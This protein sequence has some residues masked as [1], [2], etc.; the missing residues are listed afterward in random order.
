MAK[1]PRANAP[2]PLREILAKI[3]KPGDLRQLE[4]H[5]RL[6]AA[7]EDAVGDTIQQHTRLVDYRRKTLFVETADHAWIQELHFHKPQ[8]LAAMQQ[9]LGPQVLKDIAFLPAAEGWADSS[10]AED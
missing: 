2:A 8:I 9:Q 10:P 6:R 7:W 4:L 1:R 5:A 3:L